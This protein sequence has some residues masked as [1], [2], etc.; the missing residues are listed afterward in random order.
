M[1]VGY[2]HAIAHQLGPL[3]HLPHGYLNAILLP[4][5]LDFYVDNDAS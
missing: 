3:Y 1:S 4:H 5:V 2:V